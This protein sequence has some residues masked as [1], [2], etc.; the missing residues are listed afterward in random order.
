MKTEEVVEVRKCPICG[1]LNEDSEQFCNKCGG[2]LNDAEYVS[3]ELHDET[4]VKD[5]S[6]SD[7]SRVSQKDEDKKDGQARRKTGIFMAI[8][9]FILAGVLCFSIGT[10]YGTELSRLEKEDTT[11]S[12]SVE[13]SY[14]EK[15]KGEKSKG[16]S[17]FYGVWC[18]SSKD[19]SAAQNVADDLSKIG[20]NA[21]VYIS[22]D[23]SNLNQE[24][25]Y[26]VSADSC[27]TESDAKSILKKAQDAGYSHAYIKYSGE[28]LG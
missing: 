24:K 4:S 16:E 21:G 3:N 20:F 6:S 10:R 13:E 19:S 11:R 25:W 1:S 18:F 27:V 14:G 23:W 26:C 9:G 12:E 7:D 17:P 5:T 8:G 22:T 15:S 28:Y 2:P